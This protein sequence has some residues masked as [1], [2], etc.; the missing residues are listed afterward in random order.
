MPFVDIPTARLDV[1]RRVRTA[2]VHLLAWWSPDVVHFL[3]ST[4]AYRLST[5]LYCSIL[6]QNQLAL[7]WKAFVQKQTNKQKKKRKQQ[8]KL[9]VLL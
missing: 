7:S 1:R 5:R 4:S 3:L 9:I 6:Y 2:L 8:Q